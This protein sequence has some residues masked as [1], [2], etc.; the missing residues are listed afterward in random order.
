M[1]SYIRIVFGLTIPKNRARPFGLVDRRFKTNFHYKRIEPRPW[2]FNFPLYSGD[3]ALWRQLK[4]REKFVN[5]AWRT[6]IASTTESTPI[7]RGLDEPQTS[8]TTA[9][10]AHRMFAL[11]AVVA[12]DPHF[13]F[14]AQ[15]VAAH[16]PSLI[17]LVRYRTLPKHSGSNNRITCKL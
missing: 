14:S 10:G 15:S 2:N 7:C 4:W 13:H 9:E 17:E 11:H 1:P 5:I 16:S 8:R 6:R 3:I 12:I